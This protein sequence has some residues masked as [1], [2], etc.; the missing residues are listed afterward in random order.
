[1]TYRISVTPCCVAFVFLL[2]L[3]SSVMSTHAATIT[4]ERLPDNSVPVDNLHLPLDYVFQDGQTG[5]SFGIDTD[6]DNI[7]DDEAVI[8]QYDNNDYDANQF[9]WGYTDSSDPRNADVD[10]SPTGEG[11]DFLI[12]EKKKCNAD[13]DAEGNAITTTAAEQKMLKAGNKFVVTYSQ[14][15]PTNLA[16]QLWDLDFGETFRVEIFSE[17]GALLDSKEVGPYCSAGDSNH[18]TVPLADCLGDNQDGLGTTFS[19]SNVAT[20]VKRLVVS[21][22]EA[23]SGGGFAFDNFN[24]TQSFVDVANPLDPDDDDGDGFADAADNCPLTDNPDQLDTDNDTVG[25]ACDFC[26]GTPPGAV[27]D[28]DEFSDSF[29]CADTDGDGFFDYQDNCPTVANADQTDTDGDGI[30]DACDD[31]DDGD[32]VPDDEDCCPNVANP[33]QEDQDGDGEGDVCDDDDDGDGVPDAADNCPLIANADQTDFDGDGSGDVCDDDDDGD[34]VPDTTDQCPATGPGVQVAADGCT[35][36]DG[37]G[38]PDS[39]DCCPNVANP[40]QED[41]DGDGEGDVCDDDDDG[42]GVPDTVDQCP[43]TLQGA[44]VDATGC[45]D[46]DGDG[47]PDSQDCCPNVPNPGQEDSDGDGVGDACEEPEE[48]PTLGVAPISG[49]IALVALLSFWWRRRT[50]SLRSI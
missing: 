43:N 32:G 6:N 10:A 28:T 3:L 23:N 5:L 46:S 11:F 27:V 2:G 37:D 26:P 7:A 34:G 1:M 19:F 9:C 16:G 4:F 33:D 12:R 44:V 18:N 21:F 17:A 24:G 35:D 8:E 42:D 20:P 40:D 39:E 13:V 29:G 31:D 41:Q 22:V 15:L 36:T 49:L 47:V 25:D 14:T 30:G 45:A 48:I 38:V 50:K